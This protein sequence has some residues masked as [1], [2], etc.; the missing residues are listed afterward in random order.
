MRRILLFTAVLLVAGT[1]YPITGGVSGWAKSPDGTAADCESLSPNGSR[2]CN[3]EFS[4]KVDSAILSVA[5]CRDVNVFFDPD[6]DGAVATG[7]EVYIYRCSSPTAST[8][9]CHKVLGDTDGDGILN[10]VTLDGTSM[11]TGLQNVQAAWL[12]VAVSAA[13]SAGDARV[14][15]ECH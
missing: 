14:T 8:N 4:T 5:L 13:P 11:R 10:D 15:V 3:Y 6:E 9:S 2:V 7:A 1:A 12:Y